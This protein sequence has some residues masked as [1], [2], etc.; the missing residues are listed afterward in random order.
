M[1][2]Y[3]LAWKTEPSLCGMSCP[4]NEEPAVEVDDDPGWLDRDT[5]FDRTADAANRGN[6][7]GH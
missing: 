3:V 5:E 2:R 1:K 4:C 7:G 6:D